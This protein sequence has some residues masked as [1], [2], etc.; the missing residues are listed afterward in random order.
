MMTF[1]LHL[2]K[3]KKK[4][5]HPRI[6]FDLKKLK[7]PVEAQIFEA[8]IGR[9]F[10]PLMLLD[11]NNTGTNI[12]IGTFNTAVIETASEVFGKKRITKWPWVTSDLLKLCDER[13]DLKKTRYG[14]EKEAHKYRQADKQV[15]MRMLKEKEDWISD[16]C[17]DIEQN[18]KANNAKKIYQVVKGLTVTL[19][20]YIL[21]VFIL[22][23]Q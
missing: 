9:K 7:D 14:S 2:K 11:T 18:L 5:G 16:Q 1:R 17:N 21:L 15:K 8:K 13:R 23:I 12:F 3:L 10:A 4:Q 22:C 20:Q 19:C 6:M